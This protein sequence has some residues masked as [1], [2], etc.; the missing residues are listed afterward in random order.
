MPRCIGLPDG[1]DCPGKKGTVITEDGPAVQPDA[2]V[3]NVIVDVGVDVTA[4]RTDGTSGVSSLLQSSTGTTVHSATS[5][6]SSARVILTNDNTGNHGDVRLNLRGAKLVVSELLCFLSAKFDNYPAGTLRSTILNFY[7]ED[8]IMTAK[9]LLVQS[10][11]QSHHATVGLAMR[12]RIGDSKYERIVD[13][14]LHIW[15]CADENDFRKDLPIFCAANADRL[16][17]I[18]DDLS[19]IEM[20]RQQMSC[21]AQKIES[22]INNVSVMMPVVSALSGLPDQLNKLN[23]LADN[24]CVVDLKYVASHSATTSATVFEALDDEVC[25]KSAA[26]ASSDL[27][28]DIV[29]DRSPVESN[30]AQTYSTA[31]SAHPARP[32]SDDGNGSHPGVD[33][34]NFKVKTH[35]RNRKKMVHGRCLV[36]AGFAGVARKAVV[37]VSRLESAVTTDTI[38]DYLKSNGIRVLTCFKVNKQ[39]ASASSDNYS[40]DKRKSV[41]MMRVC[42][43]QSDLSKVLCE[44]L[45]PE[46]VIVRR[47]VFKSNPSNAND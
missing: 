42:V 31:V 46:G 13:D 1:R 11:D 24:R 35:R 37:C 39:Y 23:T 2:S 43:L 30:V 5:D 36:D 44:D 6:D 25:V 9:Q 22:L 40:V 17:F 29:I 19:E 32:Q 10:I 27:E 15:K 20:M 7:R 38:V 34:D 8:E 28:S 14:I 21:M 3:A 12:K 16:P 33:G 4:G 45:W 47:W 18:A 26:G 41:C